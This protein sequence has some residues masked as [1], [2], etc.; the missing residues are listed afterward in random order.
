MRR[1]AAMGLAFGDL[2]LRHLRP[3][4]WCDHAYCQ[5]PTALVDDAR[6]HMRIAGYSDLRDVWA[7]LQFR[8]PSPNL[9]PQRTAVFES[10]PKPLAWDARAA[11]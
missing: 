1:Q 11:F 6:V 10:L 8:A 7:F 9:C 3:V 5:L 2:W 4:A